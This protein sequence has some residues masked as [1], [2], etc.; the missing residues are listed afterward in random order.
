[1]VGVSG[2]DLDA[3]VVLHMRHKLLIAHHSLAEK[4]E[5]VARLLRLV[6]NHLVRKIS[7]NGMFLVMLVLH[8]SIR[9]DLM[10]WCYDLTLILMVT[11]VDVFI[12]NWCEKTCL[13]E[14]IMDRSM[15]LCQ[16]MC[17]CEMFL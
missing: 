3:L 13:A 5:F 17:I 12:V 11:M 6:V 4:T 9:D 7:F 10:G 16:N 15:S 1:M 14:H 2:S 8:V